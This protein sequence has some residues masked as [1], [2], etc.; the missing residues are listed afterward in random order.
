[1]NPALTVGWLP[2]VIQVLSTAFLLVGL[3]WRSRR[4]RLRWVPVAAATGVASASAAY[5]FVD[6][7]ALAEDRAPI[8]LWLWI[9]LAGAAIVVAVAG[10][11]GARWWRRGASVVAIP[12]CL[13]CV[14]L[15]L[16]TWT[17]YLPT[18]SSAWN[19][20]IGATLPDNTDGPTAWA[21]LRRKEK[22]AHGVMASVKIPADASGFRHRDELVYLPPAWFA[23]DPPPQL[24]AVIMVGGEFG[25]PTD[26]P[27]TGDAQ[28]TA[29]GF[30]ASHH[31]NAPVLVFSDTSGEFTNDTECVNGIRGN[32]AD[33]LTKDIVPFIVSDFGASPD[34]AHW[35]IV[36]FS[37]GGT[38][39][40][41]TTAMHPDLV[42]TFV[43]I[44]GFMRPN[45]GSRE[46]TIARLYGGDA[47]A[48]AA[49]DPTTVMTSHGAYTGIAG[50]FGVSG[51]VPTTYRAAGSVAPSTAADPDSIDA[52]DHGAVANDLCSLA[53]SAGIECAVTGQDGRHDWS[54]AASVFAA[55]LP[56]LAG[57]LGT[58]TVAATSLPGAPAPL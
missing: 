43:D 5:W 54:T 47:A 31:G 4:W 20:V 11:R 39:A 29:D 53:S 23:S 12:L 6:F 51:P 9:S 27:T 32:A 55:A 26:W 52:E 18:L 37:T 2:V 58:P 46:Q 50:W 33:H 16:D 22:P 34:S 1:V 14:A 49:F 45:A 48:Y 35:G 25:Y 44:D 28:R 3:G 57:R 15:A 30:A 13:L 41:L 36:G 56:W 21:M 24:P 8:V 7:E 17:G 38:C 19:R 10:W 42:S 40:L